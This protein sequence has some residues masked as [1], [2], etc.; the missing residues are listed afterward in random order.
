VAVV[1]RLPVPGLGELPHGQAG[2]ADDDQ[3][4]HHDAARRTDH[5]RQGALLV[6]LA[7]SPP[8]ADLYRQHTD[9]HVDDSAT[10]QPD[11]RQVMKPPVPRG[12]AGRASRSVARH[13]R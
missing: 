8:Q 3:P 4:E 12:F 2:E 10:G 5:G 13:A 9:Q 11:A 1:N 7:A 6:G